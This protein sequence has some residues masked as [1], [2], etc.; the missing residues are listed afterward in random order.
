M[1]DSFIAVF[2]NSAAL[3]AFPFNLEFFTENKG[4]I[5]HFAMYKLDLK[6][7]SSNIKPRF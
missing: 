4:G 5:P 7:M 2:D 6:K 3:D 1:S